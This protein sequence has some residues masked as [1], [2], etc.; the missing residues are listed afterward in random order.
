M[1]VDLHNPSTTRARGRRPAGLAPGWLV[2]LVITLPGLLFYVGVST[3]N[4]A[5]VMLVSLIL[6]AG[7]FRPS[8]AAGHT[9]AVRLG[10][11][12]Q[13][14]MLLILTVVLHFGFVSLLVPVDPLRAF[15]SL[16]PFALQ[17]MA[18]GALANTY[19]AAPPHLLERSLKGC[20]LL[21]AIL[22]L[23]SVAGL[24]PPSSAD[25]RKPVFPFSEPSMFALAFIPLAMNVCVVAKTSWRTAFLLLTLTCA[26][27]A[28]SLTLVVGCALV[29]LASMRWRPL[30][31]IGLLV[32]VIAAQLD[33]TYYAIRLDFSGE[34]PNFTTLVYVQGWEMI[35]E[36][37]QRSSGLGIGFQ[38]LGV[39]GTDVPAAQLLRTMRDGDDLNTLDGGF[40][41]AKLASD[42]G[43]FG[44][45]AAVAYLFLA[46]RSLVLLRSAACGKAPMIPALTFAHS[47]VLS[48]SVEFFV[49]G[50]GYF[51]GGSLLLMAALLLLQR[52]RHFR[53][54]PQRSHAS[55]QPIPTTTFLETSD[56]DYTPIKEA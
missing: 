16:V 33:L 23:L 5:G 26:A 4:T 22:A 9:L 37:L 3:S 53:R 34:E 21:L 47:C 17:F 10:R 40:V 49:R 19:L 25:W 20:Y 51:T 31:F 35:L 29:A 56:A 14:L 52:F 8:T 24:A 50:S 11:L 2:F 18:A 30:I 46:L 48:Y 44:I 7:R 39:H 27:L 36:S 12:Q 41:F 38:Q 13:E 1:A 45:L 54:E 32:G 15:G 28:Q 43:V 55:G 42:F 6:L